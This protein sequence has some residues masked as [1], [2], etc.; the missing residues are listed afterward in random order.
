MSRRPWY[1][2]DTMGGPGDPPPQVCACG[3][4]DRDVCF[5]GDLCDVC[6]EEQAEIERQE[7]GEA[8]E[9]TARGAGVVMEAAS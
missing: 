3:A 6:A 5:T 7:A 2:R 1:M 4:T 8:I 9:E